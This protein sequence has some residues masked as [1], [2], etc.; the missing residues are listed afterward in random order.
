MTRVQQFSVTGWSW[1]AGELWIL[2]FGPAIGALSALVPAWRARE[3]D[4]AGTLA[5]G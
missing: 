3:I 1:H 5:R 4:I 2:I